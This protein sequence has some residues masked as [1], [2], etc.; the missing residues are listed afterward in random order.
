[1]PGEPLELGEPLGL[2]V[3]GVF[4]VLG[5]LD[6]PLELVVL[7]VI[8]VFEGPLE[9]DEPGV[10]VGPLG[11]AV[12]GVFGLLGVLVFLGSSSGR[13]SAFIPRI[14]L[15]ISKKWQAVLS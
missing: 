7:G 14:V 8:G 9:L 11:R 13:L 4:G 15:P 12:L 5:L 3:L 2:V 6:G 1:M 10:L